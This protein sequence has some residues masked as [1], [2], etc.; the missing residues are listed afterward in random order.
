M[1]F[2][3]LDDTDRYNW[4]HVRRGCRVIISSFLCVGLAWQI[5][6]ICL[7]NC[8]ELETDYSSLTNN[9]SKLNLTQSLTSARAATHKINIYYHGPGDSSVTPP[10]TWV[11]IRYPRY[12]I[13]VLPVCDSP[14][15]TC[16]VLQMIYSPLSLLVYSCHRC[17]N[18][19]ITLL[20]T[21]HTWTL[22]PAHGHQFLSLLPCFYNILILVEIYLYD[23]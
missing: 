6:V 21:R 14:D 10:V 22:R 18:V 2:I 8:Q 4:E 5:H 3:G 15:I 23:I 17:D 1:I 20:Q 13:S 12:Q 16:V 11:L 7:E 19:V 9:S